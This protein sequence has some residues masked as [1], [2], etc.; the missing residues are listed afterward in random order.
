MAARTSGLLG[1]PS[2][3]LIRANVKILKPGAHR[4]AM[5]ARP[6]NAFQGGHPKLKHGLSG[7][8]FSKS[9]SRSQLER[10]KARFGDDSILLERLNA[11]H[12][13][14]SDQIAIYGDG[15]STLRTV[16]HS[17]ERARRAFP[18]ASDSSRDLGGTMIEDG[19]FDPPTAI[20]ADAFWA[21]H[22]GVQHKRRD[23]RSSTTA[24]D[25]A[26]PLR[27]AALQPP[28]WP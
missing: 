6:R 19:G 15:N 18:L 14:R 26:Q 28:R 24:T 17:E 20:A 13:D 16:R 21:F 3:G 2:V 1:H 23:R 11:G 8:K 7:R 5:S 12:S 4:S 10:V 22:R 25:I 9:K 27:T